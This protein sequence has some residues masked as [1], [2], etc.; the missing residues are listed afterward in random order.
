MADFTFTAERRT[1]FGKGAARRVRR[2]GRIPA[3]IYGHGEAPIHI[4]LPEHETSLALKHANALFEVAVEGESHLAVV[5]DVQKD[6]LGDITEHVDLLEV[7]KGEKINVEVPIHIVGELL[8][9]L[10]HLVDLQTLAINADA[11]NLPDHIEVSI[12]GLED[13]AQIHA[14]DIALPEGSELDTEADAL[15]VSVTHPEEEVEEAP[16]EPSELDVATEDADA[17]AASDE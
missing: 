14:G 1:D 4:S 16:A 12:D 17:A 7:V 8:P 3:V 6:A 10:I 11:T 13:G 9:G 2:S 15:V 5:K